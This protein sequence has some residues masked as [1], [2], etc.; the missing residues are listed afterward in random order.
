MNTPIVNAG[1]LARLR[2]AVASAPAAA[3]TLYETWVARERWRLA[4]EAL[5]LLLGCDP[6]SWPQV[7]G[8]AAAATD[9]QTLL[10]LLGADLARAGE[11]SVTALELRAWAT[12]RGFALP[13]ALATLLDFV[14]RTLPQVR[15]AGSAPA[16]SSPAVGLV[17][18]TGASRG[19]GAAT[20]L[21]AAARGYYVGVNYARDAAA[22][23]AVCTAIEAAGGRALALAADVADEQAVAAMF[24]RLDVLG[25]P[26]VGL[27]NN[28]GVV[29]RIGPFTDYTVERMRR[30]FD[31]NI[32]GSFLCAQAAVRRM[33]YVYG[34][35][36]GA[37]VNLSSAAARIG[38]PNEFIDYAASKGAIDA[39]TMGLAKEYATQGI[40][41]NAVRPGLIET[42]IHAAAGAPDRVARF[43]PLIPMQRAGS[44]DEVA[45]A[46]LW[47][48][49][50]EASYTTGS[51]LDVSGGR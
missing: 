27:V 30:T 45:R 17:L 31:T 9:A 37:I 23:Q 33:A 14:A 18:I 12:R 41:V 5:P 49:S 24:A 38:S 47:L 35:A 46:I 8:D 34:G 22:A 1:L 13:P 7:L 29:G 26:L 10:D 19:I 50:A 11:A 42:E 4:D 43:A 51:L 16:A 44:A 15:S 25:A 28:A 21:A 36:G 6:Q 2:T 3:P 48:L 32:L 40:R 39:F 20:A